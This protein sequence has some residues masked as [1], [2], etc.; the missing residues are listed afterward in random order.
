MIN[1]NHCNMKS[2][3]VCRPPDSLTDFRSIFV[4][5]G[6]NYRAYRG[7]PILALY[8]PT[9]NTSTTTCKRLWWKLHQRLSQRILKLHVL[10]ED[11]KPCVRLV[12][13]KTKINAKSIVKP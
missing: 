3:A 1:V 6:V 11:C 10:R 13:S 9:T 7:Q 5:L 8:V 2:P 4:E 12:L